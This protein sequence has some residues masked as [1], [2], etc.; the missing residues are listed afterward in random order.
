M[1]QYDVHFK[2]EHH[3]FMTIGANSPVEAVER[4]RDLHLDDYSRFSEPRKTVI[5]EV[6][7]S[8]DAETILEFPVE[9]I[10]WEE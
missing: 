10:E 3:G 2:T 7:D 9:P 8:D 1:K 5:Y 4:F 6:T